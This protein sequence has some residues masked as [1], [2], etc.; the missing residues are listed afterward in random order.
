MHGKMCVWPRGEVETRLS[1]KQLCTSSILVV[2]SMKKTAL[3]AIF[4]A[5]LV[6][7]VVPLVRAQTLTSDRAYQDYQYNLTVYDQAYSDFQDAKNAYLANPN[8]LALKDDARIKLYQMLMDRDQLMVVYLTALRTK[9]TELPGLS[10]D[11]KN[12][13]F[14]KIDPEV[15]FY[16]NHKLVYKRDESL[17]QLFS[18]NGQSQAQYKNTTSLVVQ[19]SL[20]DISLGQ[21]EGLRIAH[22]QIYS[23]LKSVIDAGVA[24][25][26]LKI[27]PF[28]R[29]LTDIDATDVTLK[30]NESSAKTQ[31]AQI[32]SQNYT[33][34]GGYDTAIQTLSSSINPLLQFNEFFNGSLKLHQ[35][36]SMINDSINT[37]IE[38][39][40]NTPPQNTGWST[41]LARISEKIPPRIKDMG[42]KFYA[43]K[44]IFWP[45]AGAFGLVFLVIVLGLIFGSRQPS[46]PP[47]PAPTPSIESTPEAS[48]S[49]D[50]LTVT[51]GQLKDLDSQI[52]SL[53]LKQSRLTPPS[54]NYNISF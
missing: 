3:I 33:F 42:A 22:E 50:I 4:F 41:I 6:F 18:D 37:G 23:T 48:P 30:Q 5:A 8:S 19:E 52:N 51:A 25:G 9:I 49:G 15:N 2:A 53:D 40:A 10:N 29:W 54:I 16:A 32:Y 27:D 44:K 24:A 31:I 12:S 20:F 7:T 38:P 47:G 43:N 34:Q 35:S 36:Q 1:A 21:V 46:A 28:N 11:D 13:I 17:D 14:G 39:V 26:T 45:V